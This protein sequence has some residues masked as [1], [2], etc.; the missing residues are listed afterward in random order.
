MP[1]Y[2]VSHARRFGK[3]HAAGMI[4]AYYSL[5]SSSA[6]LFDDTKIAESSD[7]KKYMNKH[8]VIHLDISSVWDF[9]KE[10]FIE[11]IHERVCEDF[12]KVYADGL[13]YKKDVYLL[14]KD[15]YDITGIPFVVIIDEWD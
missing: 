12:E 9:H 4:D 3:S 15:I 5:G 2:D 10:D 8:N 11:S 7:Y 14:L 13:N 6:A 1:F